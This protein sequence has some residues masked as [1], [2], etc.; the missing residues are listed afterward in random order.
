V[1]NDARSV[2][3]EVTFLDEFDGETLSER[4]LEPLRAFLPD[5][6]RELAELI[7]LEQDQ[8]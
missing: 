4:E 7:Q 5:L 2:T 8:E 1:R 3:V 6:M